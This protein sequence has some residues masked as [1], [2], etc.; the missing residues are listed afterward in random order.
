MKIEYVESSD[1]AIWGAALRKIIL[2][3]DWK[4]D[5][6]VPEPFIDVQKAQ[7]M[8]GRYLWFLIVKDTSQIIN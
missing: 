3:T 6:A 2:N 8:L 1:F 4:D 5:Q 7:R